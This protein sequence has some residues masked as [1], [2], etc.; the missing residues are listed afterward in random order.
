LRLLIKPKGG[1]LQVFWAGDDGSRR[2][3]LIEIR[4]GDG[5]VGDPVGFCHASK[6]IPWPTMQGFR[7]SPALAKGSHVAGVYST[8]TAWRRLGRRS[9]CVDNEAR[10]L[11]FLPRHPPEGHPAGQ[12]GGRVARVH[13]HRAPRRGHV[14]PRWRCQAGSRDSRKPRASDPISSRAP[15]ELDRPDRAPQ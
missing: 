3:F 11:D 14:V 12:G 7:L 10:D 1:Y 4:D 13:N 6:F 15:Q 5:L 9:R 8:L 2:A